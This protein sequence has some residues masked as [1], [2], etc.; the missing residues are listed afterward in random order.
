M[1]SDEDF[2][3]KAVLAMLLIAV[4]ENVSSLWDHAGMDKVIRELKPRA[5]NSYEPCRSLYGH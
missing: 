5:L 4:Q 2:L 1:V 3:R